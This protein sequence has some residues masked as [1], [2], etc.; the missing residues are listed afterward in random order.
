MITE[1]QSEQVLRM[2]LYTYKYRV[3]GIFLIVLDLDLKVCRS[4]EMQGKVQRS[5]D[6]SS[7]DAESLDR[8]VAVRASVGNIDRYGPVLIKKVCPDHAGP[9]QIWAKSLDSLELLRFYR[10]LG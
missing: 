4:P 8:S 5:L 3:V 2:R 9:F 10:T 1:V 7:F 6:K